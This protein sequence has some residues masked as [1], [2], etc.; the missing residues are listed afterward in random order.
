MSFTK[1]LISEFDKLSEKCEVVSNFGLVFENGS[2]YFEAKKSFVLTLE[3]NT[4]IPV[5]AGFRCDGKSSPLK[6]LRQF[7]FIRWLFPAFNLRSALIHDLLYS[8]GA[9]QDVTRFVADELYKKISMQNSRMGILNYFQ[10]KFEYFVL[11]FFGYFS[12]VKNKNQF[13]RK[14]VYLY[15][16]KKSALYIY[17]FKNTNLKTV[18]DI[19]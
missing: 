1:Y 3:D 19:G 14:K 10:W 7:K 9:R 16:T 4:K 8:L 11:T 18:I 12:W 17:N 6:R 13:I 2:Y 5:K 15:S